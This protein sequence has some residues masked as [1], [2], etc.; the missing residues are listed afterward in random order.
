MEL[1]RK[2]FFFCKIRKKTPVPESPFDKVTSIYPATSLKERTL[3]QVF[4]D[5]FGEILKTPFLQHL[6]ASAFVQRKNVLPIK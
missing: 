3:T 5:E 1:F 4:S 2:K 6:Q